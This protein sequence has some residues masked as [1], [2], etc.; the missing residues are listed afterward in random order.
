MK[1]LM[2][3]Y[4]LDLMHSKFGNY[5]IQTALEVSNLCLYNLLN[6]LPLI[7]YRTGPTL[8]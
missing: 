7:I 8:N 1:E 6:L 5:V 4:S 3:K 2:I